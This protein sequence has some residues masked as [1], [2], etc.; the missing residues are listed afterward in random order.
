MDETGFDGSVGVWPHGPAGSVFS[1]YFSEQGRVAIQSAGLTQG[2]G[3]SSEPLAD[4]LLGQF[5]SWLNRLLMVLASFCLK[6]KRIVMMMM[7]LM[8]LLMMM[9]MMMMMMMSFP[10]G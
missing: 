5:P 7:M 2:V 4:L 10:V 1:G 8:L 3:T 9:I 6:K